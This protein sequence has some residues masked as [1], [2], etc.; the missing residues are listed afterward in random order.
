MV[1]FVKDM[2]LKERKK[3]KRRGVRRHLLPSLF[4]FIFFIILSREKSINPKCAVRS[5]PWQA[6]GSAAQI[7]RLVA[8]FP[9][10]CCYF[11]Q[12]AS[13][14]LGRHPVASD[15][16]GVVPLVRLERELLGRP[17]VLLLQLLHF[18][19]KDGLGRDGGVDA[20]GLDG[21]DESAL[22]L[23]EVLRVDRDNA[24]LVGLRHVG[25]D[26]VHH[27]H[28]H[29]VLGRVARI[30]DDGHDVGTLLRHV[31]EVTPGTVRELDGVDDALGAHEIGDVRDGRARSRTEVEHL[32]S[33]L[34]V[35]FVEPAEDAGAQLGPEGVPDTVLRLLALRS[36]HGDALLSVDGDTWDHVLG[37]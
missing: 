6:G 30:L 20:V 27:A 8:F 19:G 14:L 23:E 26:A 32:G 13:L 25:E 15:D 9:E 31:D 22:V 11:L 28:D 16:D 33:G 3:G 37:A 36:V 12:P 18:P 2:R 21:D 5:D 35:D 7:E 17:E 24:G 4:S 29:P 1:W 34:H 10:H